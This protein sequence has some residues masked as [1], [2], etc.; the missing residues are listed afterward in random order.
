MTC[1]MCWDYGKRD[2]WQTYSFLK[3]TLPLKV[4]AS[5]RPEPPPTV[6]SSVAPGPYLG[7]SATALLSSFRMLPLNVLAFK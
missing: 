7:L 3:F 1:R 5:I 6:V 2:P 4:L